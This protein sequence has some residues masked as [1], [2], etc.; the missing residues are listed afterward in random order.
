ACLTLRYSY[1]ANNPVIARCERC[2]VN[3]ADIAFDDIVLC[4]PCAIEEE[5]MTA[6]EEG[7]HA[8]PVEDEDAA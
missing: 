7:Q 1:S 8:L 6:E 3:Y 2:E 4:R 5:R